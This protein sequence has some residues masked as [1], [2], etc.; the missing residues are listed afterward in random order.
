MWTEGTDLA[1]QLTDVPTRVV[2][3]VRR[4]EAM[5]WVNAVL[6]RVG[7]QATHQRGRGQP[8]FADGDRDL[9]QVVPVA[10]DQPPIDE[11]A[12]PLA[13]QLLGAGVEDL[14]GG[15]EEGQVQA[16]DRVLCRHNGSAQF[17]PL[18]RPS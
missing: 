17:I 10:F 11:V 12:A 18:W 8:A 9:H 16:A 1:S 4:K 2:N 7:A 15:A 6:A 3:Q 13:V 14:V 5:A